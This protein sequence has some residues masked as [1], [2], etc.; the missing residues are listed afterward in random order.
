MANLD[1]SQLQG[2]PPPPMPQQPSPQMPGRGAG[3][4]ILASLMQQGGGGPQQQPPTAAPGPGVEAMGRNFIQ[5]ALRAMER[6]MALLGDGKH[7]MQ[8]ANSYRNLLRLTSA[9]GGGGAGAGPGPGVEMTMLQQLLMNAQ[10]NRAAAQGPGP[11]AQMGQAGG[12]AQQMAANTPTPP[13]PG[14]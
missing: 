14:V 9:E 4:P 8:L 10:R 7:K 5:L 13:V 2:G 6:A 12:Q 11:A 3:S 1:P